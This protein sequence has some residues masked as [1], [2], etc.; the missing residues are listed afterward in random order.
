[1]NPALLEKYARALAIV[2][3]LPPEERGD[4]LSTL[5]LTQQSFAILAESGQSHIKSAIESD[6]LE[7]LAAFRKLFDGEQRRLRGDRGETVSFSASFE[8]LVDVPDRV[9]E[10]AAGWDAY[11]DASEVKLVGPAPSPLA[12]S[13]PVPLS[14]PKS[15]PSPFGETPPASPRRTPCPPVPIRRPPLAPPPPRRDR[16]ATHPMRPAPRA[17]A[18]AR[19][20]AAAHEAEPDASPTLEEELRP[21]EPGPA[22]QPTLT[23]VEYASLRADILLASEAERPQVYARY[24]IDP[25]RDA[26][27]AAAYSQR[28][29]ADRAL[30]A[31][32]MRHF[33][34]LRGLAERR[35]RR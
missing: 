14:P 17:G 10:R 6:D 19:V 27:E 25:K 12:R 7:T 22:F 26:A 21:T 31:E 32:Y 15:R 20:R 8:P 5:S 29:N 11:R 16:P 34:Y 9:P 28:F 1:M 30:F 33:T 4:A 2:S 18:L 13:Q 35:G 24:G 23:L 3:V